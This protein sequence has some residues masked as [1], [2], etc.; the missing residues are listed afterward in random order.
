MNNLFITAARNKYRFTSVR[1]EMCVENLWDIPLTARNGDGFDLDT[2]AKQLNRE[3]KA[4][5][6][7]SFVTAASA[8]N[9]ELK[10][11]LDIVKYVIQVKLEERDAAA[12]AAT[13]KLK[14]DKLVE[15]LAKKQ[16]ESLAELSEE[17][18]QAR[19]AALE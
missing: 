11:K 12:D 3:L 16:D 10:D 4:T 9:A 6:E 13:R 1:G 8:A 18:L 2:I 7:E 5:E 17:E 19:I 14:R 15:L